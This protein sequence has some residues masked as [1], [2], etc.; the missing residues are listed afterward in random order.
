M[1]SGKAF[2]LAGREVGSVEIASVEAE[3]TEVAEPPEKTD[4]AA[5]AAA[6]TGFELENV[7]DTDGMESGSVVRKEIAAAADMGCAP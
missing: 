6:C 3:Q 7:A 2:P 5:A 4:A 1:Q